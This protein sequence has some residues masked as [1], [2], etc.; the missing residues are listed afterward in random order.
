MPAQSELGEA[1]ADYACAL[2]EANRKAEAEKIEERVN[3]MF[4]FAADTKDSA[5]KSGDVL[6]GK[7]ISLP[8][9]EYP[10]IAK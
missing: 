8:P 1:L 9:P 2:R 4:S 7:A 3:R 6:N 5:A 10:F